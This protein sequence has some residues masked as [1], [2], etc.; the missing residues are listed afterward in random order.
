MVGLLATHSLVR[1]RID[2]TSVQRQINSRN[3]HVGDECLIYCLDKEQL[4]IEIRTKNNLDMNVTHSIQ[5]RILVC[6]TNAS[7]DRAE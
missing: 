2:R 5:R 1:Y 3:M 4:N 7:L 6:L